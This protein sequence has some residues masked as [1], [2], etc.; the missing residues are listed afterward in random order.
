MSRQGHAMLTALA[1]VFAGT[2]LP[3]AWPLNRYLLVIV[4]LVSAQLYVVN[5]GNISFE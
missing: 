2:P 3:V 5:T 4:R 1:A